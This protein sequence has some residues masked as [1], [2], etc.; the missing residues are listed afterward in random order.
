MI[1]L[2]M[3]HFINERLKEARPKDVDKPFRGMNIVLLGDWQQ[4]PPVLDS[5]LYHDPSK[6]SK[7]TDCTRP[8]LIDEI[9]KDSNFR[10]DQATGWRWPEEVP[11]R[12]SSVS[13]K[14]SSPSMTKR[15][16]SPD[17][18]TC[19]LPKN[20]HFSNAMPFWPALTTRTCSL[21]TGAGLKQTSSQ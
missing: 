16:G 4:L 6:D 10:E 7:R 18:L 2:K 15:G 3:F 13:A 17:H 5:P 19:C 14:A 12:N 11:R 8:Q 1:G 21:T 20:R 9:S